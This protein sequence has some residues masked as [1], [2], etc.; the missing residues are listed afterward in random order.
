MRANSERC[1]STEAGAG[2]G[3]RPGASL[4]QE[5]TDRIIAELD[6]GT[7]PWVKPW[8][9]AKAGLGLPRNASAGASHRSCSKRPVAVAAG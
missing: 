7:V 6:R 8:G 3:G 4:Y 2:K 5:I 9:S 1:A